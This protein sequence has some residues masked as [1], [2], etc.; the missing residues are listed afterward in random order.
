[1][2]PR[3]RY[4]DPPKVRRRFEEDYPNA[5]VSNVVGDLVQD[6]DKELLSR[7]GVVIGR[8]TLRGPD[9]PLIERDFNALGNLLTNKRKGIREVE[10]H[11]MK[12]PGSVVE[13]D[14]D[15]YGV[16]I[17]IRVLR[18][19]SPEDKVAAKTREFAKAIVAWVRPWREYRFRPVERMEMRRVYNELGNPKQIEGRADKDLTPFTPAE[20]GYSADDEPLEY[21]AEAARG[22]LTEPGWLKSI[23]PNTAKT[24]R[25]IAR[26]H[27]WLQQ[28]LILNGLAP[29]MFGGAGIGAAAFRDAR[30]P[31]TDKRD[32]G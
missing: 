7:P 16:P 11:E 10:Q 12:Q 25:Q 32:G 18:T 1:M 24:L 23:A 21:L 13:S 27:P 22:Y 30:D 29:M 20:R 17:E 6:M 2:P 3:E 14:L 26:E 4:F 31:R 8:K 28:F 15:E 19:L 5:P 9:Q